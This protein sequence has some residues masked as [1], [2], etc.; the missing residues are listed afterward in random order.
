MIRVMVRAQFK[1]NDEDSTTYIRTG[2]EASRLIQE[3]RLMTAAGFKWNRHVFLYYECMEDV[4]P[5][6]VLLPMATDYLEDW[7]GQEL[8]RKWIHLI[9]VFHFNTPKDAAHWR[10]KAPVDRQFGRV[11]HLK[12]EMV[13][14]YVYYHYQLQEEHAFHGP[15]F[16]IIGIHENLLFGYQ[17]FPAI[18]EEPVVPKKL[19]TSGTPEDWQESRMDLHFQ[20]WPDGHLYFKPIETLFSLQ[21]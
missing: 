14:S 17:E 10:R 6:E 2:G 12:P 5:P 21:E 3:G 15:K 8:S 19:T 9:D 13:A 4:I 18:V 16:E 20:P 11:A 7:P 1:N